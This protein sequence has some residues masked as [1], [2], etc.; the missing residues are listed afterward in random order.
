MGEQLDT[1]EQ[2]RRPGIT[3]LPRLVPVPEAAAMLG[4]G[5]TLFRSKVLPFIERVEIGSKVLVVVASLDEWVEELRATASVGAEKSADG[6]SGSGTKAKG[7]RGH[8]ASTPSEK[9]RQLKRLVE[10]YSWKSSG[11][12]S[13]SGEVVEMRQERRSPR[14]QRNG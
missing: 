6:R 12:A 11:A 7:S 14:G 9:N 3:R 10:K 13:P 1:A 4:V 8:A 5:E 2:S